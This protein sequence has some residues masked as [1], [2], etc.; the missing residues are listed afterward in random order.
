LRA[1]F[2]A[3]FSVFNN[4]RAR[5]SRAFADRTLSLAAAAAPQPWRR[6]S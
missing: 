2:A 1:C 4:F 6:R 3:F 5:F